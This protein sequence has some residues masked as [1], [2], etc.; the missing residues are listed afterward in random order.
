MHLSSLDTRPFNKFVEMEL[1]R[2]N[3]Y[4]S[5]TTLDEPKEISTA[6]IIFAESCAQNL[7]SINSL[8]DMA[9]E[10]LYDVFLEVKETNKNPLPLH[11]LLYGDFS[12]QLMA[13]NQFELQLGVLTY[14]YSQVR[15]RGVFGFSPSTSQYIYYITAKKS[16]DRIL[17]RVLYNEIPEA[18]TPSLT[19]APII[20]D[21]L[22]VLMPLVQ[23]ENMKRLLPIYDNLPDSDKDLGVLMVKSEYDYLQGVTLLSNIIDVSKK[24]AQDFWWADPISEISILNH[25]KEH[26]ETTVEIW[27]KSPETQGKRAITIQKEFLPIVEA[28]S[29]LSLVQHFKLLA[30]GAL[31]SGD[32]KHASKYYAKALKEYKKACDLL[33]QTENSEGQ[34]I[35]KQYQQEESELKI[36]HILTKLGLKHTIIVEKLYEQKTEEA[37]LA[38]VD[39]EK[40]LGE[41]EGTGSLPYIYGVSVAYSSA[42]TIIN[43]LLQQDL[44]H[45]NII[46]RL[47]SQFSFPLKSMSSALSEVNLSFLKVNDENPRASFTELQELDEKL[48]YLEKAIELLPSF[49]PERDHQ[50]KKVHAI[51]YYVKSLISENKVYLFADNNIVLDLILR[52]RAHYFAKKAEQSMIGI[53]KQEKEL[54]NLINERMIETKTVGMVTESSLLTLGLQSTYKNVLRKFIEEMIGVTIESEELPEF[55]AEAVEKQFAEMTEFHE[56]MDLILLDT[57][58]LI[59]TSKNVSIKGNEINWDFVKRRNIF[60]PVIKKMYEG[61]QG[62][63]LGELY[64]IVK[65]PSK[66]SSKYTKSSKNFYEVSETLGKIAEYLEEQKEMPKMIY[67][68]SLF[69]RENSK[70]IRDR[71]KRQ[72]VPYPEIVSILDY[73]LLNL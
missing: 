53:K 63:I 9:I 55:L 5:F 11:H 43:E 52:S 58:E 3:L 72:P 48:S 66:A 42:S 13:L 70:A 44:S 22:N 54:K 2:D 1:E 6:W 27:N 50:R 32:L 4:R 18:S 56:L 45:L 60:G 19:P 49:I 57:Q 29:S 71:R 36:L 40:L 23:L 31:E 24:A 67:T 16:I 10:R 28:H 61:L 62:V 69:C 46:D 15:N 65:K 39:I 12:N 8:A 73:L 68:F 7:S 47:V 14:V 34:K 33:E 20:G 21:I 35:Q 25:A 37:L 41:I 59:A 30:N 26:F 17:Y 51:R 38:C 64:A